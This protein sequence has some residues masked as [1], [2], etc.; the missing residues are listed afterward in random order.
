[1]FGEVIEGMEVVTK[2]EN[3]P[4]GPGDRPLTPVK[5]LEVTVAD[6]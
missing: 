4:T 5:M 2:I 6:Q 3:T 1:V